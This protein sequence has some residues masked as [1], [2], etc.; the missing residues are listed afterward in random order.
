MYYIY[1][2]IIEICNTI[3]FKRK[4]IYY[5]LFTEENE[6]INYYYE[7]WILNKKKNFPKVRSQFYFLRTV[8]LLD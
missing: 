7:L 8:L 4:Y 5:A 3:E 1:I 6:E 2:C